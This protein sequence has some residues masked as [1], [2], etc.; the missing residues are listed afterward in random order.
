MTG[1]SSR[2]AIWAVFALLA[3]GFL[4]VTE[5]SAQDTGPRPPARGRIEGRVTGPN[6]R[7]IQNV[8]VFVL[9]DGYSPVGNFITDAAGRFQLVVLAG[10]YYIDV[11]PLG[12]PYQRQR[13][14]IEIDPAPF[15]VTPEMFHIDIRLIPEERPGAA[16]AAAAA[17]PSVVFIQEVPK[18]AQQEF[19]RADKLIKGNKAE[20][21]ITALKKAIELFPDYY[22]ALES[23]GAEYV[24]AN[25]LMEAHPVLTKALQV[26]PNGAKS[27]YAIGVLY[28]KANKH[29]EAMG[30]FT[31]ALELD[32]DSQNALIYLGLSQLRAGKSAEAEDN[33]EKAYQKGARRVPELHLGLASLYMKDNRYQDAITAFERL[34]SENPDLRDRKKIEGLIASLKEKAKA[35]PKP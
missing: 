17:N 32:P 23:L 24:K 25:L 13:Q 15:S 11:D 33:L 22:L 10:T 7:T 30:S 9:N 19:N 12:L 8:R 26:N 1:D 29:E 3:T 2:R 31:R 4:G 14:R 5:A 21:G 6:N 27:H 18:N 35:S 20:E 28:Y 16:A 34:L